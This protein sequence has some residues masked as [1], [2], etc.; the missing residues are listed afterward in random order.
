MGTMQ[1]IYILILIISTKTTKCINKM[2]TKLYDNL[3]VRQLWKGNEFIFVELTQNEQN[4]YT[5][6]NAHK[7]YDIKSHL[8]EFEIK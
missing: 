8:G 7:L 5:A 4:N 2:L 3:T 1:K 6:N